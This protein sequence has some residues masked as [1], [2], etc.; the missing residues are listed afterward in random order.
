M[1]KIGE[2]AEG[3]GIKADLQFISEKIEELVKLTKEVN[4]HERKEKD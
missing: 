4:M 1:D 2:Y 3:L